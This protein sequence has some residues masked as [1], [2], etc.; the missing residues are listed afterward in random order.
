MHFLIYKITNLINGRIYVGLH[1]TANE[2]DGYMGSGKLLS[3]D[4]KRLGIENFVKEIIHRCS[5]EEEMER[6]EESIVN[7]DFLR[8]NVYNKMPRGKYGSR[9]RNGLSFEGRHH[10]EE[11]KAKIGCSSR[12]RL[13]SDKTLKKMSDN[14]F[15]RRFPDK[16][17]IH[18]SKAGALG[19]KA[20]KGVSR[21]SGKSLKGELSHNFG[22]KRERVQCPHCQKYGARNTMSRWHFDN[23][24]QKL[25]RSCSSTG[26]ASP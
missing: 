11:S 22:L 23:C 20:G 12:G 3:E 17:R 2:N 15:A 5:S 25:L 4:I 13:V 18:A 7:E 26:R 8:G 21:N 1:K 10:S 6:L 16:Q 24:R 19:G 14:N 9:D